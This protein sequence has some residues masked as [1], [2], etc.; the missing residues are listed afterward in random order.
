M[1]KRLTD[2]PENLSAVQR[3]LE[4]TP[5]YHRLVGGRPASTTEAQEVFS[6][7][8]PGDFQEKIVYGVYD[9]AELVGVVDLVKGYPNAVTVFIGL[10]LIRED[11]QGQGLGARTFREIQALVKGWGNFPVLRL[12]VVSTNPA[13]GLFWRKMGFVETGERKPWPSLAA[14]LILFERREEPDPHRPSST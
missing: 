4:A 6:S 9:G 12:A 5:T 7:R 13:A 14:E 2:T 3:V 11:R 8:P 10:L 1:L